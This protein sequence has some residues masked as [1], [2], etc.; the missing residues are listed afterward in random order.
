[1]TQRKIGILGSGMVAQ[2]LGAGFIKHGDIVTLGTRDPKKLGAWMTR[3][4][5]KGLVGSFEQ[6]AGFADIVVLAVSG[7]A[8]EALVRSLGSLLDGRLIID[9]TNPISEE[10]A[11]NGVLHFFTDLK[12]SL[13]ERLQQ[14]A[15][16][17]RFVKAF[18]C[19]GSAFMV[20]PVFEAG[21]PTMFICGDDEAAKKEVEDILD[22]F[23]W[24]YE[25]MG[26]VQAARAI[27][28]LCMLWCI[29]GLRSNSWGHAFKLLKAR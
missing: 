8:A 15:P 18:S 27:E 3:T 23:G 7:R 16:K 6:A 12:T 5:G 11:E 22:T 19:V 2:T 21:K 13:M 14:A 26:G 9:A 28:P 1:M 24:E 20:D 17:A 25:D 29:P 4:E 10:P